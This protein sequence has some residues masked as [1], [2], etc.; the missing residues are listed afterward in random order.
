MSFGLLLPAALAALTALLLPLAIHLARRSEQRPTPFAALRWLRHKPK[1]RHRIRFDEWPLLL[2]RLLLLAL[3]ALWLAQP[4]LFG[5]RADAT[6][7]VAAPGVDSAQVRAAIADDV[8]P[9]WLAPGFPPLSQP[10]PREPVPLASLLRQLDAELP[11]DA[12]LTVFVPERI[13]GADG[14][15]L[16]LSR[17]VD[18]RVLPGATPAREP[19]PA[20][21]PRLVVR[22]AE[23]RVPA[24]RYLRAAALAWR[25]GEAGETD[26]IDAAAETV[27]LPD[28]ARHLVWLAPGP[29]PAAVRRWIDDGGVALL[30]PDTEFEREP[31]M[32]V[33]WRDPS[34]AALAEGG[35]S[36][37]GR[38][39]RLTRPLAPAALPQLLEPDF[40]RRLRALL[41]PPP[42]APARVYAAD[43]APEAGSAAY[44]QPPRDLQPWWALL[45][46]L[47]LLAERWLATA[48]RRGEAP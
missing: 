24:L 44:P 38:I 8:E 30:D 21:P 15:S 29:L 18:W 40:P 33:A 2:L 3:L 47:V 45:I 23:D 10:P 39:V 27:P 48:R 5:E 32:A 1:P 16:R 36:G 6:W 42:P 46:A 9:R 37:R 41:E 12:A 35:A 11:A 13:D 31:A 17:T 20:A 4:V 25:S 28:D 19:R 43:Y 26:A 34:G 14:G 7:T 22:H